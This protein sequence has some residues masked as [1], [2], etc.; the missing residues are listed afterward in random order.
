[1]GAVRITILVVAAFAA[2]ILMVI[3]GRLIS[4]KPQPPAVAVAP[5]KPMTNVVV[6]AHDLTI[7][8]RVAAAD[9]KWQP[10]PADAVNPAFVT[11]GQSVVAPA[12]G[13]T[14]A[15]A[16]QTSRVAAE[17]VNA[18][19]GGHSPMEALFGAIVKTPV[20]ANE[21][22]TSA[23]LV[24]GGEGGFMAVV[25]RPGMRAIAIPVDVKTDAGG[26]VL[27]G[28]R[29][30]ILQARQADQASSTGQRP[31]VVQTLLHNIRVLAIDQNAQAPK[32][33]A[34]SVI[35]TVATIEVSPAD[36]E[37]VAL[38]KAQG[39]MILTLR[40][41]ADAGGAS[42]ATGAESFKIGSVRIIRNGQASDTTVT[43]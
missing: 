23:K 32:N 19:T 28:D 39:E 24:R 31:F 27:P 29:V 38:A 8:Q 7:G 36:A 21:P 16:N 10:W 1:M 6:A 43:P 9:L 30:D 37:A 13:T 42:G 25:L 12:P 18:V 15:V 33:G 20:L 34:Q 2:I 4:H 17:A 5:A 11:D 41:Y 14:A 22:V 40:S 26:F 3:V 35:G